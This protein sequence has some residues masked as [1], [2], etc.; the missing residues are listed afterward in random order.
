M[1]RSCAWVGGKDVVGEVKGGDLTGVIVACRGARER[2]D[3]RG[4]IERA[5][6]VAGVLGGWVN[7]MML[8]LLPTRWAKVWGTRNDMEKLREVKART[9]R[10]VL[11][12]VTRQ[13]VVLA[14]PATAWQ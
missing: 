9:L 6:E 3:R 10:R 14:S 4:E 11:I 2:G 12:A 13:R 8:L 7:P 1:A 5:G